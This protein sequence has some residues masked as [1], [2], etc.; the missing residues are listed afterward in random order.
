MTLAKKNPY[1]AVP[2]KFDLVIDFKSF[3]KK[4]CSN[5]K[6]GI[7]NENINWLNV[8]WIQVHQNAPMHVFVNYSF[9]E[10]SFVKIDTQGMTRR[11]KRRAHSCPESMADLDYSYSAKLPV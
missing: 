3:K 2:V 6:K 11:Q 8:K 7:N 1:T 9:N 5:L 4:H 10:C